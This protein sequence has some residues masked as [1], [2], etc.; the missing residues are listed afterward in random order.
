MSEVLFKINCD[1]HYSSLYIV[2]MKASVLALS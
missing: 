1:L 2:Y